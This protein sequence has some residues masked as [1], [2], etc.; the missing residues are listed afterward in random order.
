MG[1][2]HLIEPSSSPPRYGNA[3]VME[4]RSPIGLTAN[5]DVS[6][7]MS[8]FRQFQPICS[9]IEVGP[10]RRLE[11]FKSV[12]HVTREQAWSL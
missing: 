12:E 1:P 10:D 2:N 9:L 3:A 11:R 7:R 6:R 5:C 8:N 4:H